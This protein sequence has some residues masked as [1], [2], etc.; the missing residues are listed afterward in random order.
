MKT[1]V[2]NTNSIYQFLGALFIFLSGVMGPV[3]LAVSP[4]KTPPLF[5]KG[6]NL[7]GRSLSAP[8][9]VPKLPRLSP[10]FQ[11]NFTKIDYPNF[12]TESW[13][14]NRLLPNVARL[15]PGSGKDI[16]DYR[17]YQFRSNGLLAV[18]I[19]DK[20]HPKK[21]ATIEYFILPSG[22]QNPELS[23]TGGQVEVKSS[24]VT[25]QT[26]TVGEKQRFQIKSRQCDVDYSESSG[27]NFRSAKNFTIKGCKNKIVIEAG[28]GEK[29]SPRYFSASQQDTFKNK[30][31]EV[32]FQ[33]GTSCKL[34]QSKIFS[35]QVSALKETEYVIKPEG[36]IF[37]ALEAEPS[38]SGAYTT[39]VKA[40]KKTNNIFKPDDEPSPKGGNK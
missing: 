7:S 17:N 15:Q 30:L 8:P 37:K 6:P 26:Q 35:P 11:P 19:Y 29:E 4:P 1:S 25:W 27:S 33:N 3:G 16:G 9:L 10:N 21:H 2:K 12:Q 36:E 32:K 38:C 22:N 5:S 40:P 31:L 28:Y 18:D 14:A 24:G 20:N 23:K 34:S 39:F 13:S